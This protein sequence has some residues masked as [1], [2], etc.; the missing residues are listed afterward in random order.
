MTSG[1]GLTTLDTAKD[2]PIRL[3]ESG[4]AGGAILA[5]QLSKIERTLSCLF[6]HGWDDCE[7]IP[8]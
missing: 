1:G 3:V 4:P 5:E 2:Y 6:R 8:H 7:D